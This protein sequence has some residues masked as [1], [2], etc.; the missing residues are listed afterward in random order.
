MK[1]NSKAWYL[2]QDVSVMQYKFRIW[3]E[4][5][6]QTLISDLPYGFAGNEENSMSVTDIYMKGWKNL[7]WVL[8]FKKDLG[9][10]QN[11]QVHLVL[12]FIDKNKCFYYKEVHSKEEFIKV[13]GK[14]NW[15]IYRKYSHANPN[16][17]K[18]I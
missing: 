3:N 1:K 11:I 7:M 18:I 17:S 5:E 2:K 16:M 8:E 14:K 15:R 6:W 13:A 4:K 12:V 10:F 9:D